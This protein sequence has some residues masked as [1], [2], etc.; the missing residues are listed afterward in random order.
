M[1]APA[2]MPCTTD[3]EVE[4]YLSEL[5]SG[6]RFR[7]TDGELVV[8]YLRNKILEV[9]MPLNRIRTFKI[10]DSHPF[11]LYQMYGA[12]ARENAC[13]FFTTRKKKYPKGTRTDRTA[14]EGFWKSTTVDLAV[15]VGDTTVGWK[16]FKNPRQHSWR[17]DQPSFF[18]RDSGDLPPAR[19]A[20]RWRHT[21][22]EALATWASVVMADS[23]SD[24]EAMDRPKRTADSS[25]VAAVDGRLAQ[26][27]DDDYVLVKI[28]HK[29]MMKSNS[30]V[31]APQVLQQDLLHD[32]NAVA[33]D[34]QQEDNDKAL[35]PI[36][37]VAAES[38]HNQDSDEGMKEY[39]HKNMN[40]NSSF[41]AP[42]V[43]DYHDED[44]IEGMNLL[45]LHQDNEGMMNL[46]IH[47]QEETPLLLLPNDLQQED[48]SLLPNAYT[49][50][51]SSSQYNEAMMN[52]LIQQEEIKPT[53]PNTSPTLHHQHEHDDAPNDDHLHYLLNDNRE[54]QHQHPT[55]TLSPCVAQDYMMLS[56]FASGDERLQ[57]ESAPF[58]PSPIRYND[59][60][61]YPLE[62]F[63]D[64]WSE[65]YHQDL[66]F[67]QQAA[68]SDAHYYH[69]LDKNNNNNKR[70]RLV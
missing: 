32:N 37:I 8:D 5:P 35:V 17:P 40:N 56:D 45:I 7:P 34:H 65:S 24:S 41:V 27:A 14:R 18:S 31:P 4:K 43:P 57:V 61:S 44:F 51:Q 70:Q 48:K 39:H 50:A 30:F 66:M 33:A 12:I 36:T 64:I 60:C 21:A 15:V 23:I 53:L 59:D 19:G 22:E 2:E 6:Y 62:D 49:A 16:S 52:F 55:N 13:Y 63:C 28:Y 9:P 54:A 58:P 26:V 3:P 47:Q 11:E 38:H 67:A 29:N 1:A 25:T 69:E 20:R 42:Q 10:Y 46:L 68:A